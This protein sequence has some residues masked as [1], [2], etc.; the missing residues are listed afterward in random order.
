MC[1]DLVWPHRDTVTIDIPIDPANF[2]M[3]DATSAHKAPVEFMIC[4]KRDW[5]NRMTEISYLK[6]FVAPTLTK[7]LKQ[8]ECQ[9]IVLSELEEV[10]NHLVDL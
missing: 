8:D 5:K 10:A 9:L 7:N 6:Q 1:L 3:T 4:R 2:A